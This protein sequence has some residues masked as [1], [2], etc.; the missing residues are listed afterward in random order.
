M[1][2][3]AMAVRRRAVNSSGLYTPVLTGK[4]G[5]LRW[6]RVNV[7]LVNGKLLQ[8]HMTLQTCAVAQF[9]FQG[10]HA[11]FETHLPFAE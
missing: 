3:A 8:F 10:Q 4:Q 5:Q 1:F 11:T 6:G 7:F 9:P 2:Q